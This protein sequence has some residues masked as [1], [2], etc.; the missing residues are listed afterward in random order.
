MVQSGYSPWPNNF[1]IFENVY[2]IYVLLKWNR[3]IEYMN[4]MIWKTKKE[5]NDAQLIE[6][7]IWMTELEK[8]LE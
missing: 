5:M 6:I 8:M 7:P 4:E 3:K 1:G 2:L